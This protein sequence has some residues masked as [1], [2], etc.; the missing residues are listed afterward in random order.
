M[1]NQSTDSE[2]TERDDWDKNGEG[3]WEQQQLQTEHNSVSERAWA[4][5]QVGKMIW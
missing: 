4:F 1:S 5:K 3:C 2:V